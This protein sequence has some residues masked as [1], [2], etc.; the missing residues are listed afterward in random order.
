[1]CMCMCI[2]T[3]VYSLAR[4]GRGHVEGD[5]AGPALY[6]MLLRL[7][8]QASST[9]PKNRRIDLV[10]SSRAPPYGYGRNIGYN[11]VI[12]VVGR[13]L[14]TVAAILDA[15]L[16]SNTAPGAGASPGSSATSTERRGSSG[17]GLS[18]DQGARIRGAWHSS[19]AAISGTMVQY[20]RWQCR[21]KVGH[22]KSIAVFSED[23]TAR[24][25][26]HHFA[27]SAG[28]LSDFSLACVA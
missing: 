7:A 24:R 26:P 9:T 8:N 5:E 22:T 3:H 4:K 10:L 17:D 20:L 18:K 21:L 6:R 25:Q 15:H 1:M 14:W 19:P 12:K 2:Y 28:S 23:L 16:L 11:R 13:P 27:E